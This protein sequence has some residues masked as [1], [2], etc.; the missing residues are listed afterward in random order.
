M[1]CGLKKVMPW[2]TQSDVA[3]VATAQVLTDYLKYQNATALSELMKIMPETAE[4]FF[5]FLESKP[6][7]A[8]NVKA[9]LCRMQAPSFAAK[10][11]TPIPTWQFQR[12][13]QPQGNLP[14]RANL[15]SSSCPLTTPAK[16]I[17]LSQQ[18]FAYHSVLLHAYQVHGIGTSCCM[19]SI[20]LL[21]QASM[22]ADPPN[23]SQSQ[24]VAAAAKDKRAEQEPASKV[25]T[26]F[27]AAV[28]LMLKWAAPPRSQHLQG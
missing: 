21:L 11:S 16:H 8:R 24:V 4:G 3:P 26:R 14:H 13:L 12:D 27:K 23:T 7:L 22:P 28:Q 19:F 5:A 25:G 6:L 17:E 18:C 10:V 9:T 20:R 1:T 2:M 15:I